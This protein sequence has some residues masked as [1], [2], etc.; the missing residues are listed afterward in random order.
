MKLLQDLDNTTRV[1]E[2]NYGPKKLYSKQE[3]P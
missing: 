1:I 2:V 3:A